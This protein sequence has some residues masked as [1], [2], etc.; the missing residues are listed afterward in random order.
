MTAILYYSPLLIHITCQLWQNFISSVLGWII[1][2]T[3]QKMSV[4]IRRLRQLLSH[5]MC[6]SRKFCL[7][8][9]PDHSEIFRACNTQRSN[10]S[11]HKK[12]REHRCIAMRR[13]YSMHSQS[14]LI[15]SH[16]IWNLKRYQWCVTY[17]DAGNIM[18]STPK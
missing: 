12:T 2:Q 7:T 13:F 4:F 8:H 18:P 16:I 9:K 3:K 17:T 11:S 1:S 14:L 15:I 5:P 6:V 10:E